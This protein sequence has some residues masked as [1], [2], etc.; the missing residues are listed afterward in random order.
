MSGAGGVCVDGMYIYLSQ[1]TQRL[2]TCSCGDKCGCSVGGSGG[3]SL[4]STFTIT[5]PPPLPPEGISWTRCPEILVA[6]LCLVCG[7]VKARI[8]AFDKVLNVSPRGRS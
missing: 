1:H 6:G 2:F 5:P 7:V 8:P 3:V 4:A